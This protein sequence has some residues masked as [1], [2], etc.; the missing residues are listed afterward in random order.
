[1]VVVLAHITVIAGQEAAFEA[2]AR[3]LCAAT[4][5]RERGIRHYEYVRRAEPS[6]YQ[7]TLAFDDYDAFL[8]HQASSHHHVIAGA[9]RELIAELRL[10]RVEPVD[11]CSPLGSPVVDADADA[12][13]DADEI[14]IEPSDES[15][16][17]ARRDHYRTRYP[18]DRAPW[19]GGVR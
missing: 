14:A 3:R 19:W 18:L 16:L 9:M 15:V 5:E 2:A 7:A 17:A 10:E 12:D 13:A 1:M 4:L 11:G 6:T 8:E